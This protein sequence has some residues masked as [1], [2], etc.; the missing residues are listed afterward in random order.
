MTQIALT[1][2]ELNNLM[3]LVSVGKQSFDSLNWKSVAEQL[4]CKLGSMR[5]AI[6]NPPTNDRLRDAA[7][8]MLQALRD[9]SD[10]YQSMFDAMPV[11]WQTFD[12]IVS[13]AIKA[14]TGEAP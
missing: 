7:P 12:H 3:T 4:Y 13:E 2:D 5:H 1:S 10:A 9:V 8:E 14:A 6:D 11:A